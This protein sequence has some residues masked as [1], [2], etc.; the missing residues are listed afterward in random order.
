VPTTKLA[1]IFEQC[2]KFTPKHH[3]A[4]YELARAHTLAESQAAAQEPLGHFLNSHAQPLNA[5]QADWCEKILDRLFEGGNRSALA[6]LYRR[7]LEL[8]INRH[9]TVLRAFEG[10]VEAGDLA[11]AGCCPGSARTRRL[12]PP[13]VCATT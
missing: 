4:A 6:P 11:V 5:V 8:G 2:R 10:A 9:L 3:W 12:E 7:V 13:G 1:S